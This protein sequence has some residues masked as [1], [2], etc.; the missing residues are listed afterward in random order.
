MICHR[1]ATRLTHW[2]RTFPGM[3][4]YHRDDERPWTDTRRDAFVEFLTELFGLPPLTD[5][6]RLTLAEEGLAVA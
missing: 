2:L 3:T 4:G 6:E 5:T 1:L